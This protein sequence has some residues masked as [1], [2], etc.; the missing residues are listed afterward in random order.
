MLEIVRFTQQSRQMAWNLQSQAGNDPRL[1]KLLPW[2]SLKPHDARDGWNL[3]QTPMS[4]DPLKTGSYVGI[5]DD[6]A[7]SKPHWNSSPP[8][9]STLSLPPWR[10]TVSE[11]LPYLLIILAR[12]AKRVS[13]PRYSC[14]HRT[15]PR[16]AVLL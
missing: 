14:L 6:S 7:G 10:F 8:A 13:R 3:E 5:N 16:T 2:N 4:T 11:L 12:S 9:L 1:R 15:P